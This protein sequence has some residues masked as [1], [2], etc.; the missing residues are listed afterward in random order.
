M[1]TRLPKKACFKLIRVKSPQL[2]LTPPAQIRVV[3]THPGRVELEAIPAG[4]GKM[5]GRRA[6]KHKRKTPPCLHMT[7]F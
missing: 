5:P 3:I 7:A 1:L 2:R 4:G 6:G